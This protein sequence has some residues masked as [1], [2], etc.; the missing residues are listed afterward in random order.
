M[1]LLV[2]KKG[3]SVSGAEERG[4]G[5]CSSLTLLLGWLIVE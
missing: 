1:L 3:F 2:A 5:A 4:I